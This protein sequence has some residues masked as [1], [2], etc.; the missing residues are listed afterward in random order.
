[1]A[2]FVDTE[3]N[4][5]IYK[6]KMPDF[7]AVWDAWPNWERARFASMEE[8][9][10]KGDVLFDVGSENGAISCI[11]A[12][13]VG[14]ENVC[15]FEGTPEYWPNIRETW[16]A[17]GLPNPRGTWCGLVSDRIR[18]AH[19]DH[20]LSPVNGWPDCAFGDLTPA[21]SYKYI[22]EHGSD[23]P[24]ITLDIYSAKRNVIPDGITVDVEGAELVVMRGA[25]D[26]LENY[27][28]KVWISV[29]PDLMLK[30][31]AHTPRQLH[32]YMES[33]GYTANLLA[34][35]HEMHFFYAPVKK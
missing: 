16:E 35:D 26:I 34:V 20:N 1:M 27:R 18:H 22:H 25:H 11:Y 33:F 17:N 9:L 31:Y 19:V 28:P 14:G 29:H 2:T 21:R 8:N 13:F 24:Q 12:G 32:E 7:L 30:D 4:G 15:L 5:G 23:I 6:V 3:V 10:T